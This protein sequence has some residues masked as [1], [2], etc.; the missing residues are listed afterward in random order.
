MRKQH[1]K[2]G[3]SVDTWNRERERE[4]LTRQVQGTSG[5]TGEAQR[6]EIQE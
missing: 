3:P 2:K 5:E 6:Q 1:R 4:G